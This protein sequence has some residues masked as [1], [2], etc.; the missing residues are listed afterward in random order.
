MLKAF[1]NEEFVIPNP[2]IPSKDGMSLTPYKDAPL[3]VGGELNKLAYNI[4]LGRDAAGVHY[5][6]DGINGIKLGEKIAI[7]ILRD[8]R[9]TFQQEFKGFSLTTFDGNI[10]TI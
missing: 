5:R 2:V 7:G 4:A 10:I 1:F 6:T 8:Y 9:E 3:T